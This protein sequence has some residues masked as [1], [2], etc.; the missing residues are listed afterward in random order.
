MPF[1]LAC[2][3]GPIVLTFRASSSALG[4]YLAD[5]LLPVLGLFLFSRGRR[6]FVNENDGISIGVP[7]RLTS[8]AGYEPISIQTYRATTDAVRQQLQ[9]IPITVAGSPK[10]R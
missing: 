6:F 8:N 7:T 3:P 4:S 5:F 9:T 1:S 2:K 10:S